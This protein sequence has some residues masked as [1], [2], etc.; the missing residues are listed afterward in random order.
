MHLQVL[1]SGSGGN[2]ALVCAGDACVL[3]DA[4]LPGFEMERRM[5]A[6]RLGHAGLDHVFVT[7]GHLDHARAAGLVARRHRATLH[8]AEAL[9]HNASIRRHRRLSTLRIGSPMSAPSARGDQG[10]LL[11]PV[12]LPHDALPT[13]AFRIECDGRVAVILTDM[14]VP[15]DDIARRLAGAHVLVLEFNHDLELLESGPYPPALKRRIAGDAG[16]LSNEQAAHMLRAL[17][18]ENLHTLVLAHLSEHNNRPDIALET[19][20]ATLDSLGL[21][22]V[23]VLVAS[24]DEV[25]PNLAV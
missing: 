9:M 6:A 13:V 7:H 11:T 2:S 20:H 21:S 16:H 12:E 14:G 19:A 4:G 25:G 17:A 8:C 15:R 10:L 22:R 3:V 5:E 23:K 18:S 1:S 24:Q